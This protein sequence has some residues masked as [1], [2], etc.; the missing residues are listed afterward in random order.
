LS[1]TRGTNPDFETP[2]SGSIEDPPK[3]G[4][5]DN[6]D[7][8]CRRS[9][10]GC[11]RSGDG[12]TPPTVAEIQAT[13]G[14]QAASLLPAIKK[15][16]PSSRRITVR[17]VTLRKGKYALTIRVNSAR[18]SETVKIRVGKRTVKRRVATNRLVTLNGLAIPKGVNV[19]VTLAS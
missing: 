9:I 6:S 8:D 14:A 17:R 16:K 19:S 1:R 18:K 10:K 13:A 12:T 5:D 11:P 7:Y 4:N 3:G 2:N 15:A